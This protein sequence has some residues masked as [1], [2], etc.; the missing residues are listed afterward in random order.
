MNALGLGFVFSYDPFF[1]GIS[2]KFAL[3]TENTLAAATQF[4]LSICVR[5][6][7]F[8]TSLHFFFL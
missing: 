6:R 7:D 2:S 4:H 1:S 8:L 5:N 3:L